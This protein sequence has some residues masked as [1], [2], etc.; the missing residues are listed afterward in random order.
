MLLETK[1]PDYELDFMD[2]HLP[3]PE[4]AFVKVN[5]VD[6]LFLCNQD[7]ASNLK[8]VF[9]QE[10]NFKSKKCSF[11]E[12]LDEV[13]RDAF[14]LFEEPEDTESLYDGSFEMDMYGWIYLLEILFE[15]LIL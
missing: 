4:A 14:A 5:H 7:L 2:P 15:T 9:L 13:K 11:E 12:K 10:S 1:A 3:N 8:G 6:N